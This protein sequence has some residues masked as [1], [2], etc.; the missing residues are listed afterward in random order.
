[1]FGRS[2]RAR[3]DEWMESLAVGMLVVGD[4]AERLRTRGGRRIWLQSETLPCHKSAM[5]NTLSTSYTL[6]MYTCSSFFFQ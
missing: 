6:H 1:M 3:A 2:S 5:G 4:Q